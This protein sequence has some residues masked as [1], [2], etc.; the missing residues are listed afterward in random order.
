MVKKADLRTPIICVLGHIDHGKTSLLDE[1]RGTSIAEQ[2]KGAITQHI[3]ATE[4]P[5]ATIQDKCGSLMKG[6][7]KVPGLLFIDTPGHHAF[8]TLRSRGGAL[9]DLAVLVVDATEGFQ[10]QTTE[11]LKILRRFKT[12]FVLAANKIDRIHGWRPH[13]DKAFILTYENQSEYTKRSLDNLVYR[14][15]NQLNEAGFSSDRYDRIRDFQKNVGVIPISAKTGEGIPDLLMILIGLAQRFLEGDLRLH[16]KGPGMG[17]VLEVKEERGL[18]KTLDVILYDG[19]LKTGDTIIVGSYGEPI[20]T[21]VRALLKP[22]P[23]TEIRI[24]EK[25]QR[26]D[27]IVAA[28]GIKVVAHSL[29]SA[30]AGSPMRVV[31]DE[32]LVEKISNDIKSELDEVKIKTDEIGVTLKADTIGSLEALVQELND[33]KVPIWKADVG[34][35][36]KRDIIEAATI[37]DPYLAVVIGFCVEMLQDAK[38]EALRSK[39]QVFQG[40]V[41]YRL[42]E[43]YNIWVKER[44][45]ISERKELEAIIRAGKLRLMPGC[46]FRKSKPAIVGV[47]ILGGKIKPGVSVIK[48]SGINVGIIKGIQEHGESRN[49]AVAGKEAAVSIEGPTVGRQIKEGDILYVDIP[50]KH[51]RTIEQELCDTIPADELETLKEFLEI[52]RKI[53]PFWAR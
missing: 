4:V 31:E 45:S 47:K 16:A 28:A 34:D 15:I 26:V 18:G 46:V 53:D 40:N 37:R 10:P 27:K 2:E 17:T 38:D 52:K 30:L 11:A 9:A 51:A 6:D 33:A 39:V 29:E 1:I 44:Q 41:I 21:R 13:E 12:P 14:L 25:F 3:G 48:E 35:I 5:L 49:E 43:D 50:K 19:E 7:F 36:S 20:V 24:E 32:A 22:R 8:T 23:L 42:L